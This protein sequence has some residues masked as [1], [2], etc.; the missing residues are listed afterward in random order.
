MY[1]NPSELR[2][3]LPTISLSR[4]KALVS[5]LLGFSGILATAAQ[6]QTVTAPGQ[7]P[8]RILL[9]YDMEGVTG[10]N[11]WRM[12]DDDPEFYSPE[13]YAQGIEYLIGDINAAIAGLVEGGATSVDLLDTHGGLTPDSRVVER[14]DRRA[15]IIIPDGPLDP[16]ISLAERGAYEAVAAVGMHDKPLSGGFAAHTFG[17]GLSPVINGHT[18]TETELLAYSFGDVGAPVI[19]VSGDDHLQRDLGQTMPWIEYVA[20]KRATGLHSAD[21]RPPDEAWHEIRDKAKLSVQQL[22]RMRVLHLSRPIEAGL[23]PTFPM[24]LPPQ[25]AYLPG[26]RVRDGSVTFTAPDYLT[27]YRGIK[28]LV[29]IASTF[30]SARRLDSLRKLPEVREPLKQLLDSMNAELDEIESGRRPTPSMPDLPALRPKFHRA[31]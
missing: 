31:P 3:T 8:I 6:D 24:F 20:V 17:S 18:L 30:A 14:M 12:F 15:K 22:S 9:L 13:L 10:I 5:I 4:L 28:L 23:R 1:L 11:D 26:F 7:H 21:L 29:W 16:Y 19:F 25:F 27:A 2:P